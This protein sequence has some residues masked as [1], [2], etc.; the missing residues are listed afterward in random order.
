VWLFGDWAKAHGFTAKDT[1]IDLVAKTQGT[2]EFHAIPLH[3]FAVCS[4]AEVGKKRSKDDD[5]VEAFAHEIRYP[6]TTDAKRLAFEMKRRHDAES[7]IFALVNERTKSQTFNVPS[8][9]QELERLRS[10][11]IAPTHAA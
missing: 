2:E 6:A 10:K 9:S 1:G 4:D 7:S 8:I 3:S 5:I 11:I